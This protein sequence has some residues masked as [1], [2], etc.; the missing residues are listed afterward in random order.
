[1]A[2]LI[3]DWVISFEQCIRESGVDRSLNKLP[4]QNPKKHLTAPE[5]A[6]QVVFVPGLPPSGGYENVV[7]AMDL[8][9][10][11]FIAQLTSNQIAKK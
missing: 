9:S 4:Q 8:F 6:M 5:Y 3:R 1:M 7:A 2:Q 11:Y 10:S